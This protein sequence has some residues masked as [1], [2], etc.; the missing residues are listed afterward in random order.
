VKRI[1]L[2]V[3]AIPLYASCVGDEPQV[4]PS[5]GGVDASSP[6]SDAGADAALDVVSDSTTPLE[7][8]PDTASPRRC[9]PNKAFD[10]PTLATGVNQ[11]GTNDYDARLSPDE[12]TIYFG[13]DR[14]ADRLYVATR[15]STSQ[16]FGAPAVVNINATRPSNPTVSGDQLMLVLQENPIGIP[17]MGNTDV[18]M[19]F[20]NQPF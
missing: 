3:L 4:Q 14:N 17:V 8:A 2:L 15:A 1:S 6:N 18:C 5:G 20:F 10:A 7:A 9:D 16:S 13:S 12:L 11:L 19:M